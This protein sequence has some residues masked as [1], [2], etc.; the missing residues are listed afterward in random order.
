MRESLKCGSS[1]MAYQWLGLGES[2]ATLSEIQMFT[3]RYTRQT[4]KQGAQ[5]TDP[6]RLFTVSSSQ[7]PWRYGDH[8]L[9]P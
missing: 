7:N 8:A 9:H 5:V 3:D 2:M 1:G 4:P 6:S